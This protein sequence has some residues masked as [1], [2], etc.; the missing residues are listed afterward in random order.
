MDKNQRS[1]FKLVVLGV[2]VLG[3]AVSVSA[4]GRG[5]GGGGGRGSGGGSGNAG[6]RP[7]GV[8]VDRGIGNASIRSDGRSDKGLRRLSQVGDRTQGWSALACATP[9]KNFENIR[10]LL[11]RYTSMRMIC[12]AVT[13]LP[14]LIIPI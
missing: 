1:V 5:R 9:I 10:V 7:A 3:L 13:R 2:L 4:Q 6:G 14:L 12:E 11:T 8:G